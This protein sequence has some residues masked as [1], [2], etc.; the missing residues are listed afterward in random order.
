[1]RLQ[2]ARFLIIL[3]IVYSVIVGGV[4]EHIPYLRMVHQLAAV[5]L[6][7]GWLI[8]LWRSRRPFPVTP[9]DGPLA[10][11]G[12]AFSIAALASREPRMSL[13]YAWVIWVHILLFYLF[14]DLMRRGIIYQRWIF[15]GVFIAGALIVAFTA[16]E[17]S[18]WYTG[19]S[20]LPQFSQSW[21]EVGQGPLPP[22]IHEA[23]L[24]LNYNNSTAAACLLL[25]PLAAAGTL[26]APA[27][28][29][30]WGLR[31][32][33]AG[34]VAVLV[35]TQSRGGYLGFAALLGMSALIVILHP[36]IRARFP[37]L[38]QPLLA[39]RVL[40][41]L[42]VVG[43]ITALC[44]VIYLFVGREM[45]DP[46][47]VAR[48]DMWYSAIEIFEDHPVVGV[49]PRRFG[50][51]KLWYSHWER[52]YAYLPLQH[53]HSM[54]FNLLAEGG[55][56]GLFAV[57]WMIVRFG[58]TWW[59]SWQSGSANRRHRLEGILIAL[60][61]FIAHN[62]VDNFVQ[63]QLMILVLVMLAYVTAGDRGTPAP[64]TA[65]HRQRLKLG[66]ILA[67]LVLIQIIYTPLHVGLW[68]HQRAMALSG[69]ERLP[70][71]LESIQ[72]AQRYDPW[73]ELYVLQEASILG[74][75]AGDDPEAYL[76]KA[77]AMYETAL[78]L[79]PSWADG[80]FNLSVLF[81]QAGQYTEA[82]AAAQTAIKWNTLPGDYHLKLGEYY[83]ALGLADQARDA[84]IA[85]LRW[86]PY[87]ASSPFWKNPP[88]SVRNS[89]PAAAVAQYRDSRPEIALDIAV[90]AGDIE[91]AGEI[92]A[93]LSS[94]K[95]SDLK[96]R[97][98]NL[99]P[100][101]AMSSPCRPCYWLTLE[102][103]PAVAPHVVAAERAVAAGDFSKADKEARLALFLSESGSPWAWYVLAKVAEWE[104]ED[105]DTINQY[106]AYGV[107][108]LD[109]YRNSFARVEY[110]IMADLPILPLGY[111]PRVTFDA[112]APWYELALRHQAAG[113]YEDARTVYEAIIDAES[114]DPE[115]RELLA[116]LPE[117]VE[118]QPND[119]R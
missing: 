2:V 39:P 45:P 116:A 92:V 74:Q 6:F 106:L 40:V 111:T 77:I 26:T 16:I 68:Y 90:Y 28:D 59:G 10:A 13:E 117:V 44:A 86:Q 119:E 36:Q 101:G 55:T 88:D 7:I 65:T 103:L 17:M 75:L 35:F 102:H 9:F 98:D 41:V 5:L 71:A 70:E 97:L 107:R 91:T 1:M 54:P 20:V 81:A 27:R 51:E 62:V 112:L 21:L 118:E 48:L 105:A 73:Q 11:V 47:N 63:T 31:I 33:V 67:G 12:V 43:G 79:N 87:L 53:A 99:W 78:D 93:A 113:E 37:R 94:D 18:A 61:A 32:I 72:T 50:A 52:S 24:A 57:F 22:V 60:I 83:E 58:R 76:D 30:R 114:Y 80:W 104:E 100:D 85:A 110:G 109:D 66:A 95:R 8:S 25:I 84:W 19:W 34:L 23:G 56:L 14:V 89:V 15:E 46:S 29:L 42:A 82:A 108:I 96:T 38:I 3:L 64:E 4:V 69:S 49:G 115:A